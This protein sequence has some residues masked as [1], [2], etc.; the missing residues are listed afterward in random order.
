MGTAAVFFDVDFTLVHPGP[1]FQASGYFDTCIRHGLTVDAAKFEAAVAGAA[2]V[3]DSTDQLFNP[4]VYID[5]TA[6]IIQ[7]MGGDP[8]RSLA[9]AR[10]IYDDWAVNHHF[11]LYDDVDATLRELKRRGLQLGLITNGHR[12]LTAFQSH[13]E[14]D[15]LIDVTLSSL[16]HGY[17]KPHASIFRAALELAQVTAAESVMVGDSYSHDVQGAESVGMR[18]VLIARGGNAPA[19]IT[20]PVIASLT[21]LFSLLESPAEP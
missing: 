17:M 8:A 14:L 11:T 6:R 4:Q 7:L 12:S 20:A 16:Q 18:G 2:E 9:P 21:E 15:G 13:F 1:R 5:Y 10:E 3:L 19:G